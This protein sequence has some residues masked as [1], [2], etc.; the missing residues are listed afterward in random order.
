MRDRRGK[1][2]HRAEGCV[3]V[4]AEIGFMQ[5]QAEGCLRGKKHF[6]QTLR[7][8][9]CPANTLI[10]TFGLQIVRELVSVKSSSFVLICD[11]SHWKLIQS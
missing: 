10:Q 8:Q 1:D 6:P 4:G 7:R 3:K 2:R 9:R 11:C 5:Q